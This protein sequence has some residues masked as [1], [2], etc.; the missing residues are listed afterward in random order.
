MDIDKH[1]VF[2]KTNFKKIS[3]DQFDTMH[4][5]SKIILKFE[6]FNLFK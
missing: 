6:Y 3:S 1:P 4:L 2:I 5:D